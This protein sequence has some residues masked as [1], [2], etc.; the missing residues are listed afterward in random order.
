MQKNKKRWP[1]NRIPLA[2]GAVLAPFWGPAGSPKSTKNGPGDEKVRPEAPPEAIFSIFSRRCRPESLSEPIFGGSDPHSV[3][4]ARATREPLFGFC[5]TYR[6]SS[7]RGPVLG[8]KMAKNQRRA[9]P[10]SEKKQK[11]V[12]FGPSVFLPFFFEHGKNRK[13]PDKRRQ[14]IYRRRRTTVRAGPADR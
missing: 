14:E 4:V 8:P 6:K 10:K 7:L 11:K 13:K 3:H 9:E 1:K 2:P 5:Q 12:V